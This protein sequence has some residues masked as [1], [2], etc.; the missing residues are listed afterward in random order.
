M[1]NLLVSASL[2]IAGFANAAD[3]KTMSFDE[4]KAKS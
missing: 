4:L 1:K 3:V 2:L